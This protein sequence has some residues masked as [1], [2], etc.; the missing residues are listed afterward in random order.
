MKIFSIIFVVLA[1]LASGSLCWRPF[2]FVRC[3]FY[4]C[5]NDHYVTKNFDTLSAKLDKYLFG[6]PLVKRVLLASLKGHYHLRDPQKA[7][8]L[9]FHGSTGV[10]KNFVSQI[11]AES[12]FLK[13]VKSKY[14]K[15]FVATR[16]FPHNE[17]INEYKV[18][19]TTTKILFTF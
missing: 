5:C 11:V 7:L 16:D 19:T 18:T 3:K 10:G 6:Q 2:E 13:G 9:S 1:V 17:K 15:Q 12:L 4:E 14:F 8:V